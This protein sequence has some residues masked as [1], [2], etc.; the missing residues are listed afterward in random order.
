MTCLLLCITH[1]SK[2]ILVASHQIVPSTG[3]EASRRRVCAK[4]SFNFS[5][6]MKYS[7]KS[8][9]LSVSLALLR[10]LLCTQDFDIFLK[11]NTFKTKIRK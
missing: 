4:R 9:I 3:T 11:T 10:A 1:K 2:F 8:C 6:I 5:I 7:S